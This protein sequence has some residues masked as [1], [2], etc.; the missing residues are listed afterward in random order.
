[1]IIPNVLY[2]AGCDELDLESLLHRRQ[3]LCKS[4]FRA[5]TLPTHR[6]HNMLPV[7]KQSK[8]NPRTQQIYELPKCKTNRYKNS[9]IPWCLFN[10]QWVLMEVHVP[11]K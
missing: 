2:A 1:M 5:M 3:Q 9:F 6:L 8:Y 7:K 11:P 10:A 4:F